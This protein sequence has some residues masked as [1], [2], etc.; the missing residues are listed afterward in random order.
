MRVE[1]HGPKGGQRAE[2]EPA[3]ID[4]KIIKGLPEQ[5]W[6]QLVEY[7]DSDKAVGEHT[8]DPR[9]FGSREAIQ[10]WM[11]KGRNVYTVTDPAEQKLL[12]LLWFGEDQMPMK[13]FTYTE[14][15]NPADYPVTHALRIYGDLRKK[16]QTED[17]F[18]T[19]LAMFQ[20]NAMVQK[21]DGGIWIETSNPIIEHSYTKLG[22]RKITKTN[23]QEKFLMVA[24]RNGLHDL[25]GVNI[26]PYMIKNPLRRPFK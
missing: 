9:R 22:F 12:G 7:S 13:G 4:W 1:T 2:D 18:R 10:G 20:M 14:E 26:Q 17:V 25:T 8:R 24:N 19:G 15:I 23:E 3:T 16:K 21:N 11:E 6:D 5:Y